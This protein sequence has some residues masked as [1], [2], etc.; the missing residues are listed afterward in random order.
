[1]V[2]KMIVLP[3][4]FIFIVFS[5]IISRCKLRPSALNLIRSSLQISSSLHH[6]DGRNVSDSRHHCK[7]QL[8]PALDEPPPNWHIIPLPLA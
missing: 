7:S 6:L 5:V 1:M 2:F 4:T 3:H 8:A